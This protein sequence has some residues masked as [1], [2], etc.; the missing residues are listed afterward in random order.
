M[1]AVPFAICNSF[2][3]SEMPETGIV[4]VT[5]HSAKYPPSWVMTE[6]TACPAPAAVIFPELLTVQT[7]VF[8]D[9]QDTFLLLASS[10]LTAAF[11]CSDAPCIMDTEDLSSDIPLTGLT[12]VT[13]HRAVCPLPEN[14]I[15]A[16]SPGFMPVTA[17]VCVTVQIFSFV[18]THER[19][20]SSA[21]SGRMD[22]FSTS[23]SPLFR[24]IEV[25]SNLTPD[26]FVPPESP[27]VL[28]SFSISPCFE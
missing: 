4:T 1:S 27:P 21:S 6:T 26:T 2:L 8:E 12:T 10:G 16:A 24:V 5:A 19:L 17:P 18:L 25:F 23:V 28:P 14:T 15:T 11:S 9:T 7:E 3:S 20:R 22:A 13:P